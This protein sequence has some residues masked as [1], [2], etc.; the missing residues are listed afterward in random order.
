MALRREG[1]G[2]RVEASFPM[3]LSDFGIQAPEYLG[4]GVGNRLIVSVSFVALPATGG[5]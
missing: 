4:V 1:A 3:A 2:L 5:K